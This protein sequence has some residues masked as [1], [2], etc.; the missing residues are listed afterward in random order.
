MIY[1]SKPIGSVPRYIA[2]RVRHRR[3]LM[4]WTHRGIDNDVREV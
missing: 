1:L 4:W 2:E 3:F